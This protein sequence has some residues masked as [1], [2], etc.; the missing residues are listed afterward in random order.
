MN[1]AGPTRVE[2]LKR[3]RVLQPLRPAVR[4]VRRGALRLER[5]ARLVWWQRLRGRPP[6]PPPPEYKVAVIL[7]YARRFHTSTFIETGTYLGDT[8][9]A[10]RGAFGRVWS[11]ELDDALYEAAARRF[12]PHDHVTVVHGDSSEVLPRILA[13][14]PGSILFWLDGHWSG[15]VTA[16]GD[17][18]TPIVAELEAI[19]ARAGQDDVILIDDAREFAAGDYPPVPALAAMIAARRPGWRFAVKDDIIRAHRRA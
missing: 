7:D 3:W 18:D 4:L 17:L 15:G 9:E 19:L 12:A 1:L 14:E 2:R 16:R 11:V 8:I 5:R 13:S 6:I 10:V